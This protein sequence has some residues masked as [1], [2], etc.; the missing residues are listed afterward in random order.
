MSGTAFTADQ[1]RAVD[2]A[3]RHRDACVTAGPGSGKTT[4]LVE[5]F[6]RLV[7]A[8]VD[9]LRILSI[10]FTEKAAGNMRQK[11]AETFHDDPKLRA[12]LERAWVSTVHGFCSRLVRENAVF[13]GVDPEFYV[14]DERESW[15]LQQESIAA[16]MAALFEERPAAVR[17]LIRGLSSWEFE[18]ALL[19]AYD[20]MRGAGMTVQDAAA[21]PAPPGT[22]RQDIDDTL[23]ALRADSFPGWNPKQRYQAGVILED[24]ARIVTADGPLE[25][26]RAIW[27]FSKNLPGCKKGTPG[28]DL[29]KRLQEQIEDAPYTVITE[30]YEQERALLLDIV[31]RFDR[32]YR[33]RKRAAGALDFAD[34]EE[35][36]VRLLEENPDMRGRLQQ[37]F[38]H[39]LM[40]ELQD[41]NGQ[42]AKLLALIR[43]PG[44]FFAV[45]DI[46]QSIFGFRHADPEVFRDYRASVE[47]E[48]QRLIELVANF[49]SR[50][51][52]LRAVETV[53]EGA[54]GVEQRQLLA[55]RVFPD[56]R[57]V[58]VEVFSMTAPDGDQ[59]LRNE[60]RWVARRILELVGA[61]EPQF[62]F[63]DVAVLVRNTEVL[64]EFTKAFEEA[65]IPHVVN[66]GKGFYEAREVKDL[67]H[68]LRVIANPRDEISLTA[69]LRSPLVQVSDEALL[70]LRTRDDNI[71][72]ALSRLEPQAEFD[73][74]DYQKLIYF[75]DRLHAWRIRRE[76]VTFDRLLLA[77]LDDCGYPCDSA[78]RGWA[79]IEKFLAQARMA[80]A[81]MS[82]DE[83]VEELDLVRASNPREPDAP[84]E[85][86]ADAVNVMTVHSAKGLEFSIVFV[87]ALHKGVETSPPVIAFSRE[88][89][90]GARWR[91][92]AGGKE[93]EKDDLFQHA[94]RG[95]RKKREEEESN[96]LLYVAMSRAEQHL[97]LSFSG[98][99]RK[100]ENW[101]KWVCQQLHLDLDQPRDEILTQH[102]PDGQEWKMRLFVTERVPERL[103]RPRIAQTA[104]AV[105]FV[106]P[107]TVSDQQDANA[108]VTALAAFAKCP[109]RY[110]LGHYL[111]FEGRARTLEDGETR[112]AGEFGTE[113]HS[114]LAGTTVENPDPKALAMAEIFR[115]S[116]LGRRAAKASR[117]EREF[118]F[119]MAVEG[120]VLRGQVDLWFEEGGDLVIVDYKTDAVNAVEAHQRAQDY[121]IQLR[122]YALA[123]E[124]ITGRA[125]DR[126]WLHFLR[127]DTAIEIDL[128]PSLLDSPEQIVRDFQYA[129]D[130][131]EFPMNEGAHC[132]ACPFFQDLC[133]AGRTSVPIAVAP[134]AAHSGS[135][136]RSA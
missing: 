76:H 10:T 41:T 106:T 23:R 92:P 104:E 28:Y 134:V 128:T 13:A 37:Q 35:Y 135:R 80:A 7:E 17:A 120:L 115:Q 62:A 95:E 47:Q 16:A 118:D 94:I 112:S 70:R 96:R 77:A 34:L 63:R 136:S 40:D 85:D 109:R 103:A 65:G 42:Q 98:S 15:R 57:P 3:E 69:V 32:T 29:I 114:L 52:I 123:V 132:H 133:P 50:P 45:G 9:P 20:A 119:L 93:K 91:N 97:V 58:P 78:A 44:R 12:S 54:A 72:A 71:G 31:R 122:L 121:T 67:V 2:A 73:P 39:V 129:Q 21:I 4:V 83:F 64:N 107:P 66:R 100:L 61:S 84:P 6:R 48:G 1:L 102:A 24:A 74:G 88:Y 116:P 79:N 49:R 131:L 126:A 113:V 111:G 110:Y 27:S 43:R 99:G 124:R 46:N 86:S 81:R 19:S 59:A 117:L 90:L 125:P 30:L 130:K 11:L 18:E 89:G 87:A 108:T 33:E 5:Y 53:A 55:G 38:D 8:G 101:A 68:L 51:E 26:L 127:P 60:A 25:T 56:E 36:A 105:E 82:L 75:R 14:A 22:S